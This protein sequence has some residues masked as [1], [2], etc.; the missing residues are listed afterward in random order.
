M[1]TANGDR[2]KKTFKANILQR[3][4]TAF[5]LPA[6]LGILVLFY[7]GI[8]QTA[9]ISNTHVNSKT[10]ETSQTSD[11]FHKSNQQ[12]P[13]SWHGVLQVALIKKKHQSRWL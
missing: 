5:S 7:L 11:A 13:L 3:E 2:Y 8:L 9:K 12:M 1:N 10:E 4:T 6:I